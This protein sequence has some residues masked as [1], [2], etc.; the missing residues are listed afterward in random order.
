MT[1]LCKVQGVGA[2]VKMGA[3]EKLPICLSSAQ[4]DAHRKG[5]A[6]GGCP[7]LP[8][9]PSPGTQGEPPKGHDPKDWRLHQLPTP[10]SPLFPTVLPP[11]GQNWAA[12]NLAPIWLRMGL[13]WANRA[14]QRKAWETGPRQPARFR[15]TV[16]EGHWG[17]L[18]ASSQGSRLNSHNCERLEVKSG[19][20]PGRWGSRS[21]LRPKGETLLWLGHPPEPRST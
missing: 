17:G 5:L 11:P 6:G 3:Q 4:A 21:Q 13:E 8:S 20:A 15:D 1:S 9:S 18:R 7:E 19:G 10:T 14:S 16:E 12:G 2:A